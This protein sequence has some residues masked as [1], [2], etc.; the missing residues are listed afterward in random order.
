MLVIHTREGHRPDMADAPRAKVERGAPSLRIGAPGP[1]GRILIRGAA[2]HDIVPEL[3]PQEGEPVVDKPGKGAFYATDL[4]SILHNHRIENLIVCGVTTEVC[5]HTTVREANDR[6]YRCIVPADCCGSYFPE[7]HE[8]GL[9]MIKAQGGM[10]EP[11]S[12][13]E[14]HDRARE[15]FGRFVPGVEP[16]RVFASIERRFGAL[17]SFGFDAVGDLWA[18][19]QLSRRDRSLLVLSV[20]SAQARDEEL[21]LHTQVGLHHGL[22]RVEIEEVLLH[23]AAYAGFPAAMAAFA[24][25]TQPIRKAEGV[26][27]IEQKGAAGRASLRRRARHPRRRRAAHAHRRPSR[28]RSRHRPRQHAARARRRRHAR[29]PLCVRRDLVA[30]RAVRRDRSLVVHRAARPRSG[31]ERELAFHVP[32][33]LHHGLTRGE[34]EEIMVHLCLYAGFPKGV[35]GM[36]AARGV[37][38]ARRPRPSR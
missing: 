19:P 30:P 27:R 29:L 25:R 8:V 17:G 32:A 6:G 13:A 34:I 20:L 2:G 16:D 24:G 26:E 38:Q 33:G 23:V 35:D 4:H 1:M 12:Y 11:G 10:A 22:T 7:F 3:Y 21:E 5:V 31:R 37:R 15:V 14:R 36:R 9:R 18:R 28:R